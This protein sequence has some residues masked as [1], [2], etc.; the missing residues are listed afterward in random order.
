MTGVLRINLWLSVV[1]N[2]TYKNKNN[3]EKMAERRKKVSAGKRM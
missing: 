2:L 1:Y 3:R